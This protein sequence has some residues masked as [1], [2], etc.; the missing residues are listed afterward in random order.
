MNLRPTS[1]LPFSFRAALLFVAL[2]AGAA[3]AE[4]I[5]I[6]AGVST[7]LKD[8]TGTMWLGDQGFEDG[9]TMDRA[10][11]KIGNTPIPSLYWAERFGMSKFTRVLPNGKY[12]VKLHFAITYEGINGPGEVVFSMNV[13]GTMVKNLDIWAKAGGGQRAYVETVPVTVTDGKLDIAFITQSENPTISGIE[14]I[15]VP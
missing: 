15:P 7:P 4:T 14:I 8:E 1:L 3:A 12:T 2:A 9:E 5:R 11:L 10:G 13:E 6:R